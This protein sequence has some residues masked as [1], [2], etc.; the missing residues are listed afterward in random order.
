MT[1]VAT[2]VDGKTLFLTRTLDWASNDLFLRPIEASGSELIPVA[3]GLDGRTSPEAIGD[4]LYLL[5][6][7]G[8]PRYRIMTA[9][10]KNPGY[11]HWNELIPQQNG[12]I[13]S[14]SVISNKLV[15][16]ISEDVASKLS[17]YSLEGKKLRDIPFPTLGTVSEISGNRDGQEMF[18]AFQ[19]FAYPPTNFRYEFDSNKLEK[20][21]QLDLGVDLD[22][23]ETVQKWYKSKDGT[24]VPM[25]IIHK[26]GIKLN[27]QNPTVLY[28]Y[29]G[30]N[31]SITPRFNRGLPVWLDAGGVYAIANIRGG[32]EFGQAWHHAG[33]KDK[34]Q[35]VYDDF[36]A[37]GEAL[38]DWNITSKEK[39]AIK[40]GSNGGLLV[41][42]VSM[43]RPDLFRAVICAVPLLDMIRYHNFEIARLWI[44]EYGS[45]EDPKQFKTLYAYSP[46]HH[47]KEGMRY[48]SMLIKTGDFDSRVDPMHAKK[49]AAKL[50]AIAANTPERPILLHV[51]QKAGHGQGKPLSKRMAE[52][53]DEWIYLM[54]QLGMIEKE[55]T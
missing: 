9:S 54:W 16:H 52:Q 34:K 32:G 14:V 41:G 48:P 27:G 8:A 44:P 15:L 31:I 7:V 40:G 33:R 47:V 5:T 30:F 18:F 50:Q 3:I 46:Y 37:A 45:A 25:F 4:T 23:Y 42:A 12:V 13:E 49:M 1:S 51:E 29:G 11:D 55:K 20:I 22:K 10:A 43:Q 36:I 38:I 35:N 21:E 2:S 26:K 24:P 19:S 6:S 53:A 17:I 39:L 28:G